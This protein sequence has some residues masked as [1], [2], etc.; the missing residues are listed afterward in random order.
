MQRTLILGLAA[1]CLIPTVVCYHNQDDNALALAL[2]HDLAISECEMHTPGANLLELPPCS[3]AREIEDTYCRIEGPEDDPKALEKHRKCLCESTFFED[4]TECHKC[5]VQHNG[6]TKSQHALFTKAL[7]EAKG[8]F[9][10]D[11]TPPSKVFSKFWLEVVDTTVLEI[12]EATSCPNAPPSS[13]KEAH[14]PDSVKSERSVDEV[15]SS[16]EITAPV[17]LEARDERLAERAV[18]CRDLLPL[19]DE[20]TLEAFLLRRTGDKN[21]QCAFCD[22]RH[23]PSG[24]Y[25]C[26]KHTPANGRTFIEIRSRDRCCKWTFG[27]ISVYVHADIAEYSAGFKASASALVLLG[28]TLLAMMATAL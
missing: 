24:F 20:E 13:T 23:G 21:L 3:R 9:C 8:R 16:P 14:A 2:N 22:E 11:K 25:K 27:D 12:E 26:T 15:E 4:K 5:V 18:S 17:T 1:S 19:E 28:C 10:D 6:I 7:L